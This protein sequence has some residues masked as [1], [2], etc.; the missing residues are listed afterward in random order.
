MDMDR[1]NVLAGLAYVGM[2]AACTY[3][4]TDPILARELAADQVLHP[5]T[6]SLLER[7]IRAGNAL[8]RS[9]VERGIRQR[10]VSLGRS[11]RPVIK[12][13]PDPQAAFDRLCRYGLVDLLRMENATFWRVESCPAMD[14]EALERW[15][16]VRRLA[17]EELRPDDHD[18]ALIAP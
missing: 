3:H 8:D 7:A 14:G 9:R 13:M 6:R 11:D 10:S 1:R 2:S 15:C 4:L 16:A 12:W 18:R 5:F 17:V